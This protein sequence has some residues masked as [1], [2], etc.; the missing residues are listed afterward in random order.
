MNTSGFMT[1]AKIMRLHLST[2]HPDRTQV[3][4]FFAEEK[5]LEADLAV[6]VEEHLR[7]CPRCE[8][9]H[10]YAVLVLWRRDEA[11]EIE[12]AAAAAASSHLLQLPCRC[13]LM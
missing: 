12:A 7:F 3:K 8:D 1:I 10:F 5:A 13:R 9:T 6:W 11:A 4:A 2:R